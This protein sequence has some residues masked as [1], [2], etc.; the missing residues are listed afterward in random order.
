MMGKYKVWLTQGQG[1]GEKPDTEC[2]TLDEALDEA[3]SMWGEGSIGVELPDGSWYDF[4]DDWE[5]PVITLLRMRKDGLNPKQR[6]LLKQWLQFGEAGEKPARWLVERFQKGAHTFQS[7]LSA[8]ADLVRRSHADEAQRL[9]CSSLLWG[10][11][12]IFEC[13]TGI[14]P[15][16]GQIDWLIKKD[17]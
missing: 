8:L 4:G 2:D 12:D 14:M 3:A 7:V 15:T 13:S 11:F 6:W 17:K 9:F 1:C 10:L 5:R 16:D